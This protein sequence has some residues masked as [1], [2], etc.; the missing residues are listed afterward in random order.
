MWYAVKIEPCLC[1]WNTYVVD[2]H[3][4]E[5][6]CK[7]LWQAQQVKGKPTCIVAKTFKGKGL[8]SECGFSYG[9]Y[10]SRWTSS[11]L[12]LWSKP[13]HSLSVDMEDIVY[14][15]GKP[16][17]KDKVDDILNDLQA[18]IQVPNKTLCPELPKDDT[19]PADLSPISLPSPPA[20]KKGDKVHLGDTQNMCFIGMKHCNIWQR[21]QHGRKTVLTMHMH[22]GKDKKQD[23]CW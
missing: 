23:I 21:A 12:W 19:A 15:H 2:G 5:E 22:E 10:F 8:K 13:S 16:I 4:V 18:Q 17:P 20:Y 6:L 7:A 9:E 1:R 14:W 3:D 11:F